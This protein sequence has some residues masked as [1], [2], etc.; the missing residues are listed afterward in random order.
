MSTKSFSLLARD[1][2][3]LRR[4]FTTPSRFKPMLPDLCALLR[5]KV[6]PHSPFS[7]EES[8]DEGVFGGSQAQRARSQTYDDDVFALPEGLGIADI[9]DELARELGEGWGGSMGCGG[10]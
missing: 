6:F 4:S 9:G 7:D 2:F 3:L 1:I 10:V 5:S 8:E